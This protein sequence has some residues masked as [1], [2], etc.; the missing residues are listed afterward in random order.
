MAPW[1]VTNLSRTLKNY[2]VDFVSCEH[3]H[4]ASML[5]MQVLHTLHK[6][7]HTD[8]FM[9]QYL[10]WGENQQLKYEHNSMS[11]ASNQ[12]LLH[13]NCTSCDIRK[14]RIWL[15]FSFFTIY[16][17]HTVPITL[18]FSQ[19]TYSQSESFS[20]LSV[21]LV[22]DANSGVAVQSV[23]AEI[24]A[25]SQPGDT[26]TG[27]KIGNFIIGMCAHGWNFLCVCSSLL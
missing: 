18:R 16:S 23:V 25:S 24:T 11:C 12:Q 2:M 5:S 22:L 6:H 26:A 27:E 10:K 7:M 17:A 20:P 15:F 9:P 3:K 4:E 13:T 21:S 14:Q 19:P 1:D 8:T